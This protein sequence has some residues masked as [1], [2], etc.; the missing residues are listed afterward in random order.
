MNEY[1]KI[2]SVYKRDPQTNKFI[3]GEW[4]LPE[5]NY[6]SYNLWDWTE[7]VDGTNIRVMWDGESV[8]FGGRTDRANIPVPLLNSLLE[9]FPAQKFI[10]IK[11]DP[12][13][14][15]GEGYGQGIQK[16][17]HLYGLPNFVLFDV[18]IGN[19]WLRRSSVVNIAEK[20][21]ISV[22]PTI[23]VGTLHEAIHKVSGGFNSTWGN[24]EAEGL[25]LRPA[26]DLFNRKGDRVITKIK[27]RDFKWT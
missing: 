22:V 10:D 24:F 3:V 12:L 23:R 4:T 15:Y 19:W 6:L 2:Q 27:C 16:G 1:H 18:K 8:R 13:C 25:V 9:Q 17:G 21:G 26:V 11:A 20:L 7:K 5:F 14:L